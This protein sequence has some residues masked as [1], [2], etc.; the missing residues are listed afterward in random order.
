[1]EG[2]TAWVDVYPWGMPPKMHGLGVEAEGRDINFNRPTGLTKNAPR[3]RP[4]RTHL[5]R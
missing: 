5:F 2:I 1:M 3:H 4:D